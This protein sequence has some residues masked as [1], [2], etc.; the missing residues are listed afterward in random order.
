MGKSNNQGESNTGSYIGVVTSIHMQGA[1]IELDRNAWLLLTHQ[2]LTQVH[3]LRIGVLLALSHVHFIRTLSAWEKILLLGACFKSHIVVKSFSSL[4][5]P[6]N[7]RPHARSLLT[8]YI[9]SLPFIAAFWVLLVTACFRPK[10]QG[11]FSEKEILGSKNHEG[12]V[13]RY[14]HSRRTSFQSLYRDVLKEFFKHDH[15]CHMGELTETPLQ[16]I[17]PIVNFCR[18]IE[19]MWL[20]RFS[21]IWETKR[22]TLEG[23]GMEKECGMEELDLHEGTKDRSFV[24]RIISSKELGVILVGILQVSQ[25]SG[26]LQLADATGAIDVVV[27]DFVSHST[28]QNIYEVTDFN[29]VVEGLRGHLCSLENDDDIQP[30]SCANILHG[31]VFKS[32]LCCV[33]YYVHFYLKNAVSFEVPRWPP[34]FLEKHGCCKMRDGHEGGIFSIILVTHK[35][36]IN[37]KPCVDKTNKNM[38]SSFAEA[39]LLPYSIVA[40]DSNCISCDRNLLE[41]ENSDGI[42]TDCNSKCSLGTL[43]MLRSMSGRPYTCSNRGQVSKVDAEAH[44]DANIKCMSSKISALASCN[45]NGF[46]DPASNNLYKKQKDSQNDACKQFQ[47]EITQEVQCS[48]SLRNQSK[49]FMLPRGILFKS[50]SLQVQNKLLKESPGSS[51][52]LLEFNCE[53]LSYYQLLQIGVCYL[54]HYEAEDCS[55][56]PSMALN[57]MKTR[58]ILVTSKNPIWSLSISSYHHRAL[59]NGHK[60]TAS[61]RPDLC[62]SPSLSFPVDDINQPTLLNVECGMSFQ[63]RGGQVPSVHL[64]DVI[65]YISCGAIDHLQ[66]CIND[67]KAQ[68]IPVLMGVHEAVDNFSVCWTMPDAPLQFSGRTSSDNIANSQVNLPEGELISLYGEVKSVYFEEITPLAKQGKESCQH[69]ADSSS[70]FLANIFYTIH[71]HDCYGAQKIRLHGTFNKHALPLGFGPGVT[72]AFY[73]FLLQSDPSGVQQLM[74]T[75]ASFIVINAIKEVQNLPNGGFNTEVRKQLQFPN[76]EHM[77]DSTLISCLSQSLNEEYIKLHCRVVSV[78]SLLLEWQPGKC[79]SVSQSIRSSRGLS[80]SV[81]IISA[82]FVLDDGSGLCDCWASGERAAYLLRIHSTAGE[83]FE[84]NASLYKISKRSAKKKFKITIGCLLEKLVKKHRRVT[85]R[86][87]RTAVSSSHAEFMIQGALEK[88]LKQEEQRLICYVLAKACYSAPLMI[89]GSVLSSAGPPNGGE[90]KCDNVELTIDEE[91]FS[92][93]TQCRMRMLARDVAPISY[94]HEAVN[95]FQQLAFEI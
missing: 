89:V 27:P 86:N 60:T 15:S 11:I 49:R 1:L 46:N 54:M 43:E 16:L 5:T 93:L 48:L 79:E 74:A 51:R 73:R 59:E 87:S 25:E 90:S 10:F 37:C 31:L 30:L 6:F 78:Q 22:A 47:S 58:K 64:R 35:Y 53:S 94:L 41:V 68:T 92:T 83:A 69:I 39:V 88:N 8:R 26:K 71:I 72:A 45:C 85:V 75:P 91:N 61:C 36:A 19:A 29:V 42:L 7:V 65:L 70:T 17:A 62:V 18:Q 23:A 34:A 56:D 38:L 2:L 50:T 66:K 9:E 95:I 44:V 76:Y 40:K 52:V 32:K 82:S 24:R 4:R 81:E 21:V 84:H 55:S 80:H 28:M 14:A 57:C 63:D 33:T 77:K 67:V 13:Q 20:D 12:M 3:G